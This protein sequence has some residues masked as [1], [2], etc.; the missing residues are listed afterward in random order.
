MAR[1]GC[2]HIDSG[3]GRQRP[4]SKNNYGVLYYE[5]I[6][7][8]FILWKMYLDILGKIILNQCDKFLLPAWFA[9][10]DENECRQSTDCSVSNCFMLKKEK[11]KERM[12]IHALKLIK[13]LV[14]QYCQAV[15]SDYIRNVF[16]EY[17]LWQD[18]YNP[19]LSIDRQ[20]KKE[21]E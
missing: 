21:N 4:Y 20:E 14:I 9:N 3:P 2:V 8:P 16:Y 11:V 17:K 7:S 6:S 12:F 5:V 15:S 1:I 10:V 19:Y 13:H 18:Y